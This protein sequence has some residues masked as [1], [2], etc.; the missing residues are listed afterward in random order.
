MTRKHL[1]QLVIGLI[2][3]LGVVL[4]TT[5]VIELIHWSLI[6]ANRIEAAIERD[7]SISY[8]VDESSLA[9]DGISI[10][11]DGFWQTRYHVE[12]GFQEIVCRENRIEW[13]CECKRTPQ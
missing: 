3:T 7:C 6:Q 13:A 10:P 5:I 2:Y 9:A 1:K 4:I 11:P 8:R 12:G